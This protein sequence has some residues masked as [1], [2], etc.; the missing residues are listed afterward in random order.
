MELSTD[1]FK[2]GVR[3]AY[4]RACRL[5]PDRATEEAYLRLA[6]AGNRDARNVLFERQLPALIDLASKG[7]Y[8]MYRGNAA[9][10]VAAV[11]VVFDR[12]VELF[13]AGRGCRFWTFLT[14]HAMNAMNKETY[15]DRLVH[16]PEN[17]VKAGRADEMARVESGH[18]QIK[19]ADDGACLFDVLE[20]AGAGE[21]VDAAAAGE[22]RDITARVLGCLT[23]EERDL[24]EKCYLEDEP[25]ADGGVGAHAWTVA[26]VARLR[27]T[28]KDLMRRRHAQAIAKL[29]REIDADRDW[30]IDQRIA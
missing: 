19:D 12:A 29:R 18:A 28:S 4:A 10:L 23:D 2:D 22:Y 9:E 16:V 15:E 6:K 3:I 25:G 17:Y 8:A 27:G 20:G 5:I 1:T 26:S 14:A 11:M 7:K 24:V 30:C 21:I 13:D